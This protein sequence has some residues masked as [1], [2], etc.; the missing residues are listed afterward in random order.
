MI[1]DKEYENEC[2]RKYVQKFRYE[3]GRL[4]WVSCHIKSLIGTE[5]G[6]ENKNGYS[7]IKV[8]GLGSRRCHQLIYFM[9]HGN[10]PET[11]DHIDGNSRN[12]RIENL[13]AATQHQNMFNTKMYANNKTGYKG[14]RQRPS[15]KWTA[16][17]GFNN[18][19]VVLGS[20]RSLSEAIEA[21]KSAEEKYYG[22]FARGAGKFK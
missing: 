1:V 10:V 11:I 3:D 9:H 19:T 8:P 13:R 20:F 5:A 12:N 7:N 22:E 2:Y 4:Y 18:K 21:R 14:I 6:S 15:G 16:E 17:I